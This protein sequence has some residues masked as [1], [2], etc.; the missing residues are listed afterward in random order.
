[1]PKVRKKE[2]FEKTKHFII[3]VMM[4]HIHKEFYVWK[5]T[6]PNLKSVFEK[7]YFLSNAATREMFQRGKEQNSTPA[8]YVLE[9]VDK[10]EAE[11]FSA[12]VAWTRY[13][14][15]QGY[16]NKNYKIPKRLSEN[17]NGNTQNLYS[18]IQKRPFSD[19]CCKQNRIC[20]TYGTLRKPKN[21]AQKK[22]KITISLEPNEYQA[23]SEKAKKLAMTPAGY[24]KQM[25]L[26]GEIIYED[27]DF[28]LEYTG[29]MTYIERRLQGIMRTIYEMGKYVPADL[30]NIQTLCDQVK[31][32]HQDAMQNFRKHISRKRTKRK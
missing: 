2:Y 11:A 22:T 10:P 9:A 14:Q 19:V 20:E 8:M 1:M 6:N 30:Q 4:D 24:V 13:F 21:R 28:F 17:L 15:D 26:N 5:T 18:E 23:L 7:H 12:C 31:E 3:Y 32:Y 16:E 29:K 27:F 25:S